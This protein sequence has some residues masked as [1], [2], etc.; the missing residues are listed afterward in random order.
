[1]GS[2]IRF[3]VLVVAGLVCAVPASADP[4]GCQLAIDSYNSA[5][6][7]IESALRT[8]T[9]CLSSS[10]GHDDCSVEFSRLRSA[11]DDFESAVSQYGVECD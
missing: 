1:M 7:D 6:S 2:Y 3:A 8:Y 10:N 5:V 4:E 11:H 9:S